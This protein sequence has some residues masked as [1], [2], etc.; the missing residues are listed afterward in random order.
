LLE[1]E[2]LDESAMR[3]LRAALTHPAAAPAEAA[4]A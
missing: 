2:T 4:P 3:E 1:K